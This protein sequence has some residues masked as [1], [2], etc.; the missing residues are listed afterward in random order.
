M[1]LNF[2]IQMVSKL[3]QGRDGGTHAAIQ[4]DNPFQRGIGLQAHN[5]LIFPV[6]VSRREVVNSRNHPGFHIND[7]FLDLLHNQGLRLFPDLGRL[8]GN[9][10]QE[11]SVPLIG[12]IVLLN[13]I[14]HIYQVA[15][16]SR[17][18]SAPSRAVDINAHVSPSFLG[19]VLSRTQ[20]SFSR[21]FQS[22][23]FASSMGGT[24][25]RGYGIP[26]A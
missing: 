8:F 25:S 14:A 15:P 1:L 10:G 6:N 26:K 24:P 23:S 18:K 13:K 16:F 9:G 21:R 22:F 5:N 12:G 11:T 4:V 7:P 2:R 3:V 19:C 17:P 20:A